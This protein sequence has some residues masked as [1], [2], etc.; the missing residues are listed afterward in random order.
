MVYP[1]MTNDAGLRRRLIESKVFVALYWPGTSDCDSLCD[2]ILPLP[3]D[4]RYDEMGMKKI[5]EMV[6]RQ[7]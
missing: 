5:V 2:R 3:I 7:A 4:Q 6:N 1:Y